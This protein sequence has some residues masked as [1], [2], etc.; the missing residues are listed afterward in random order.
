VFSLLS[1][2]KYLTAIF[3][4]TTY[5]LP[6]AKM[7]VLARTDL[8]KLRAALLALIANGNKS[9][10]RAVTFADIIDRHCIVMQAALI[11]QSIG[12]GDDAAL[13]WIANTLDGPGLLPSMSDAA[14]LPNTPKDGPAQAWF[15][16][17][18]AEHEAFRAAHP[19]PGA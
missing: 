13:K 9:E 15:D 8:I 11:E 6:K 18:L 19:A 12:K 14:H 2:L 16:A 17:K 1:V 10:R 3:L 4:H 5:L 7:F